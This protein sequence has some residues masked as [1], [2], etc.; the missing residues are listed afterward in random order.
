MPF[1]QYT[2]ADKACAYAQV[3]HFSSQVNALLTPL[4]MS[5]HLCNKAGVKFVFGESGKVVNLVK[6]EGK[7]VGVKTAD[8]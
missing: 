4:G 8:G 7:V 2:V 3:T 1:A 5:Q 6:E